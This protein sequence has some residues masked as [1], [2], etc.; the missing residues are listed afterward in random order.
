MVDIDN[1]TA[2]RS[3][4]T[5][6]C[7]RYDW[8]AV[9]VQA[10]TICQYT[11]LTDKNGNKIWENDVVGFLDVSQYDNGYSEHYCMG[12]VVWDEETLSFQVT[13]RLSCESYEALDGDCKV[14]GNIFDNSELLV[15]GE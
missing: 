9:E 6:H 11:G 8:R 10:N 15:G 13:E 5:N 4:T 12:K 14:I 3:L 7:D 1:V 2:L